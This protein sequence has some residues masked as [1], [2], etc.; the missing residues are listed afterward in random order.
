MRSR[1]LWPFM[2]DDRFIKGN[3]EA[4]LKKEKPYSPHHAFLELL[5]RLRSP[6]QGLDCSSRT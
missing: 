4:R 2:V 1:S 3:G 5:L 6:R